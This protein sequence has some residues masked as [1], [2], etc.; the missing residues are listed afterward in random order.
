MQSTAQTVEEYLSELAPDR[1][2]ALS[3]VRK[4]ILDSLPVGL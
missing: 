4:A 2:H 1:R 3:E